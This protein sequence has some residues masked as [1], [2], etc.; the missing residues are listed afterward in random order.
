MGRGSFEHLSSSE[1]ADELAMAD[2][3]GSADGD[4][5]GATGDFPT[6]KIAVVHVHVLRFDRQ[7]S[8]IVRIK[9]TKGHALS[10]SMPTEC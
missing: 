9:E 8:A 7:R 6:F 2:L 4:V 3:D 10:A 1:N 5:L